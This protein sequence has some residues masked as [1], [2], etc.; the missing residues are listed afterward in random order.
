MTEAE[1]IMVRNLADVTN[2]LNI[3]RDVMP[4]S[5]IDDKALTQIKGQLS[6]WQQAIHEKIQVKA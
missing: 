6:E 3:L 2:A 4:N 1:Y 5:V